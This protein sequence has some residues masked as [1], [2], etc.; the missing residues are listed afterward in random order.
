[1]TTTTTDTGHAGPFELAC[2]SGGGIRVQLLWDKTADQITVLVEDARTGESLT[3][4][5][6]DHALA[7]DVFHHPFAH[8]AAPD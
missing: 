3:L 2:R 7:L 5:V 1:M 6:H 8:A 4:P